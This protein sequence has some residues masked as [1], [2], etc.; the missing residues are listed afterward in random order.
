ML[1]STT[2]HISVPMSHT[3]RLNTN[4]LCLISKKENIRA[5]LLPELTSCKMKMGQMTIKPVNAGFSGY[6]LLHLFPEKMSRMGIRNG[7]NKHPL[8]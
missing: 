8:L 5:C 4:I 7:L 2:C 3:R 1:L 6:W